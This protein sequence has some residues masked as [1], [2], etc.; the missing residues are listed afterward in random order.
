M[1]ARLAPLVAATE[2]NGFTWTFPTAPHALDGG[3]A[4]WW[5]LPTGVRSFEV[6]GLKLAIPNAAHASCFLLHE[7]YFALCCT[8]PRVLQAAAFEGVD[9]SLSCLQAAW[10][11]DG[12]FDCLL[13]HSQVLTRT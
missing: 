3:G 1:A 7:V 8:V 4:A 12:P 11:R 6:R 2:P 13:G 5:L 10:D 9:E